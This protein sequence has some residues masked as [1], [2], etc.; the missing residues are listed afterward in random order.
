MDSNNGFFLSSSRNERLIDIHLYFDS[1]NVEPLQGGARP[2]SRG[3]HSR[4]DGDRELNK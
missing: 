3:T 2:H 4:K 1:T